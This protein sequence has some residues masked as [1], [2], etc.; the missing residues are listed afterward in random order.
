MEVAGQHCQG[1]TALSWVDS[2]VLGGQPCR[3]WTAL[4]WVDSTW[5]RFAVSQVSNVA[6]ITGAF[7]WRSKIAFSVHLDGFSS[8]LYPAACAL[9][10]F[11]FPAPSAPERPPIWVI[12]VEPELCTKTE[13]VGVPC[14]VYTWDVLIASAKGNPPWLED[15]GGETEQR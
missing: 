2:I 3:G 12:Y 6:M 7:F 4:L 9:L 1:R 8:P 10:Y 14:S 11:L 5:T 13:T 15:P